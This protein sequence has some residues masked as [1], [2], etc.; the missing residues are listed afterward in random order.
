[1]GTGVLSWDKAAGREADH[2]P[3]SSA[4]VKNEWSYTSTPLIFL[5]VVDRKTSSFYEEGR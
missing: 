5:H 4:E 2:S 3:S 1:M